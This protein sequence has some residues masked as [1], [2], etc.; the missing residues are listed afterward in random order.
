MRPM[1]ALTRI[2]ELTTSMSAASKLTSSS[3]FSDFGINAELLF[4]VT[5]GGV[6]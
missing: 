3:K 2:A 4:G 5:S 1:T 6:L